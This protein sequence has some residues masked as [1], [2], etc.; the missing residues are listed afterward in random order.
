[1]FCVGRGH[2]VTACI[3]VY[4][5]LPTEDIGWNLEQL[6]YIHVHRYISKV[7]FYGRKHV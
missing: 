4:G 1:M 5:T 3:I 2:F 7:R 6:Q